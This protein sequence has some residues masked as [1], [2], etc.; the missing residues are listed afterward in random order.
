MKNVKGWVYVI[1][2]KAMPGL[3][4]IGYSTKDPELRAAELNHTGSPH[5]YL[6]EYDL[7]IENPYQIEQKTHK[8]LSSKREAKEWFRCTPEEAVYAIKQMAGEGVITES[9][10]RAEREK[11]EQLSRQAIQDEENQ[12]KAETIV[13]EREAAIRKRYVS[14]IDGTSTS[15][16]W[17]WAWTSF[18]ALLM[19]SMLAKNPDHIGVYIMSGIIGAIAAFFWQDHVETK[20][21]KPLEEKMAAEI[22]SMKMPVVT[23]GRCQQRIRFNLADALSE[24]R[25]WNCPTCKTRLVPPK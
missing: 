13:E 7:L 6:V 19:F 24:D 4:K 18:G 5:P 17:Y 14:M 10:K 15:F 20:R 25:I 12:R 22:E 11:A 2:N 1:S 3:V 9:F 23:C 16:Y 8:H 21:R